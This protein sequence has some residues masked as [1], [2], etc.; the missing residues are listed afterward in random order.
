MQ[1]KP[2]KFLRVTQKLQHHT[3]AEKRKDEQ[4]AHSISN[5]IYTVVSPSSL[6]Q[7]MIIIMNIQNSEH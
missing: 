5:Y 4:S 2:P 7:G 3:E 1:C 6:A